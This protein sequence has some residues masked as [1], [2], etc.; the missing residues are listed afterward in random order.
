[1]VAESLVTLSLAM[2][3]LQATQ[4]LSKCAF[5]LYS[6]LYNLKAL[7]I[8]NFIYPHLKYHEATFCVF[9]YIKSFNLWV[10]SRT[11]CTRLDS[12]AVITCPVLSPKT[13]LTTYW[14]ISGTESLKQSFTN[15]I[16]QKRVHD[17]SNLSA[18]DVSVIPDDTTHCNSCEGGGRQWR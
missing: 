1:M 3:N 12:T 18:T 10:Y 6:A 5:I 2:G 13:L 15:V 9:R 8:I 4:K 7:N 16:L 11:F 17:V 14:L